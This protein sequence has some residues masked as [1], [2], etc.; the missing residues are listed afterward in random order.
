MTYSTF[1]LGGA[2]RTVKP[3]NS[4]STLILRPRKIFPL[5][6]NASFASEWEPKVTVAVN[7][8]SGIHELGHRDALGAFLALLF[9]KK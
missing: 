2:A 4:R 9:A 7:A 1:E 3:M 5:R 8:A 6:F